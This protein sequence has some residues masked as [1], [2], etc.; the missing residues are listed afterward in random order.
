MTKNLK[1]CTAEIFF[2]FFDQQLQFTY[3]QASLK[4][5]QATGE[6]F[7]REHLALKILL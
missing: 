5:V 2:S 4:D 6:A 7:K 3:P 1:K